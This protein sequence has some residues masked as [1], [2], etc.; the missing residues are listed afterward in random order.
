MN[1]NNQSR[2]PNLFQYHTKNLQFLSTALLKN[3]EAARIAISKE[4][5]DGVQTFVRLQHF[6]LGAWAEVR[7][8][9]LLAEEQTLSSS[10]IEQV[11][12]KQSQFEKWNTVVELAYR[13]KY[14]RPTGVID[15][16][17]IPYTA[18]LQYK[19]IIEVIKNELKDIIEIR[20]KMAHGQWKFL[21]NGESTAIEP[22]KMQKFQRENLQ[23]LL[24]KKRLITCL[25]DAIHDIVISPATFD[26]D[27]DKHFKGIVNAKR[28]LK[29]RPYRKY[30][31][32]LIDSYNKGITTRR[33]KKQIFEQELRTRIH[34]E[35][36]EN[37]L[38][39]TESPRGLINKIKFMVSLLRK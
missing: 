8:C 11:N 19:E 28:D 24:F 12:N 18:A 25:V 30:K 32:T 5:E 4:D 14:N 17:T 20:N 21:L 26:R 15:E 6:L 9:K 1:N 38:A 3:A 33:E 2:Q 22:E 16:N 39:M 23:S 27:F 7:L 36:L 37:R 29:N 10:D 13:S 31:Q 34:N 35:Y